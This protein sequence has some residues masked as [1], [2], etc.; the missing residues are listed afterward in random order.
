[1]GSA[2]DASMS[3]NELDEENL[4]KR[5]ERLAIAFRDHLRDGQ[6]F[7]VTGQYRRE[8]FEEVID[9]VDGVSFRSCLWSHVA[10]GISQVYGVYKGGKE[11]GII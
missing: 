7:E 1:M 10:N 9:R 4:I 3:P 2:I 5:Q 6:H 8:F 11:R